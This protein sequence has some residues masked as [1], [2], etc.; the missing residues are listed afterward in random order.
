MNLPPNDPTAERIRAALQG[1]AEAPGRPDEAAAWDRITGGIARDAA[2]GA[3]RRRLLG[4]AGLTVAGAAAALVLVLGTG[5]DQEAVE[6]GPADGSTTTEAPASTTTAP[7]GEAATSS[8]APVD[9]STRPIE[10]LGDLPE[11]PLAVVV[12]D[13]AAGVHR[14]DL[15]DAD[16]GE[17]VVR[18]LASSFH[19]LSEVSVLDDGTVVYTE[20]FG[21][22]STVR[23]AAW[24]GSSGPTTP[25][26]LDVD[27]RAG[28][29]S[30]DGATFA[31]VEQG[32][33]RPRGRIGLVPTDGGGDIRYLEWAEDEDDFF[34]TSGRIDAL[35]FSPDGTRLAFT[36]SYEGTEVLVVD[37]DAASLSEATVV[38]DGLGPVWTDGGGV[39]AI[40]FCCYPDFGDRGALVRIS[41]DSPETGTSIGED[42]DLLAVAID[43]GRVATV[44]ASRGVE[45]GEQQGTARSPV[46]VDGTPVE[47]GL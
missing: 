39:V 12:A 42:D 13:E 33:T 37:L 29:F 18:N 26:D 2:A 17:L 19:S 27:M 6:V 36:S 7:A 32:V 28:T 47:V 23:M 22:S 15:H 30:P 10:V 1:V 9:P 44:S 5:D 21:D 8:T 38:G 46:A 31:Y 41:V 34:L 40:R 3:R 16:T 43:G 20:E 11:H 25:F 35:A 4:G 45:V 14:L 24:D